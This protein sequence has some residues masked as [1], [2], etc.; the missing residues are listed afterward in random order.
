ML[1]RQFATR[2]SLILVLASLVAML[3]SPVAVQ[4]I[5]TGY[6]SEDNLLQVGMVAALTENSKSDVERA[7]LSNRDRFVG[8]VTTS[9]ETPLTF[10]DGTA[11]VL[12]EQSGE[13]QAYVSDIGGTVKKGDK[14]VISPLSGILMKQQ[15]GGGWA[16]AVASEDL[17]TDSATKQSQQVSYRDKDQDKKANITLIKTSIIPA[18]AERTEAQSSSSS[19]STL[20]KVGA[21]IAGKRVDEVRVIAA[22][23]VF[24]LVL[25][26]EGGIIYGAVTSAMT[27][28]GRNPLARPAVRREMIKVLLVALM[29]LAMGLAA[30]YLIMWL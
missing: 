9:G 1:I 30:A 19:Q 16:V 13:V 2:C 17:S 11:T 26:A 5:A 21:T 24:I 3:S 25:I 10:A 12:V 7:S 15:E 18:G 14:L 22:F 28:V 4:A 8:I 29:V 23:I 6:T 27:A 20:S